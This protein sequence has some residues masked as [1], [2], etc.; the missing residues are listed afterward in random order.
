MD[1]LNLKKKMRAFPEQPRHLGAVNRNVGHPHGVN[2]M[3]INAKR[4]SG[5]DK[6]KKKKESDRRLSGN[7]QR[8]K[9]EIF[10]QT[11]KS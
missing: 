5:K 9:A 8:W 4:M 10:H 2:M 7:N 11:M 6:K 3:E 1:K